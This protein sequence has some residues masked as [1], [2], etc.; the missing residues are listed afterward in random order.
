MLNTN[1]KKI[2]VAAFITST[3]FACNSKKEE[4]E[5]TNS[6]NEATGQN[7]NSIASSSNAMD[8]DPSSSST[9]PDR[10]FFAYDSS[11]LVK[12]AK[13]AIDAQSKFIKNKAVIVEGHCDDRGTSEYNMALGHK[14]ADS[15]KKDLIK[16]GVSAKNIKT[17]SYG[18]SKP[19]VEGDNESAY[20][21]NRRAV[22]LISTK[23]N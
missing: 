20:Q 6:T 11:E 15:V 19:A 5:S 7:Q 12:E 23:V 17:V 16:S 14:R 2:V 8:L 9:I 10:V 1:L 4:N 18:K 13:A 3:L 22:L 21:Q